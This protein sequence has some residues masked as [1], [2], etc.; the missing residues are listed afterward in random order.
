MIDAARGLLGPLAGPECLRSSRRGWVIWVRMA[1]ALAAA[2][3]VFVAFWF[4]WFLQLEDPY[5]LPYNEIRI[6]L[7]TVEGIVVAFAMILSPAVL[8]G[9]LAGEKERG[10]IGLLLTTR[11][12]ALEIVLGRL[13]G[14]LSQ[15]VM[16]EM[17]SLPALLLLAAFAGMGPGVTIALVA[18]PLAVT[19]GGAGIALGAS[20]LSRRGRDA[21]LF[22]YLVEALFLMSPLL[23]SVG[24]DWGGLLNPFTALGPLVSAEVAWP[25]FATA[26]LWASLGLACLVL[27]AWRLRVSCLAEG[28]EARGRSKARRRWPIPPVNE[29][30]ML[31]KELH[32]ERVGTL[33]RAGRWIGGALVAWLA[34]GSLAL[35]GVAAWSDFKDPEG[36][37]AAWATSQL[38]Y[39]YGDSSTAIL[40][41]IEL[42][43]GLR[44]AVGISSERERGT[45]DAL[46]TS[47][48]DGSEIVLGKLWGS[49]HA[50]RW[51]IG[52][53]L[54][55]W[56]IAAA[57]GGL[58]PGEYAELIISLATVGT[59]IAAIGVRTSLHAATATRSMG[60]TVGIAFGAYLL[61][62]AIAGIACF[63]VAIACVFGWMYAVSAGMATI[64]T[65]PWFPMTLRLGM[66]LVFFGLAVVS[67][68]LIVI[69]TRL[70]FDRVAG[71]MT[72]GAAAVAVEN[73]IHGRPMAPVLLGPKKAEE[74]VEV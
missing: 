37:W 53:A 71:R 65:P 59:L 29:R 50:L 45:W 21:L 62:K 46:L 57:L 16:I 47:P 17:A 34:L 42:A 70:R 40:V 4:A 3:V 28:S 20:S 69:E 63:A 24:L 66:D 14:R 22:V 74:V 6:A 26:G 31:W 58:L 54:L 10:S 32:I 35:A 64:R 67:T 33:G 1:S 18:L 72:G 55:A 52:S 27:G 73:L 56:T 61:G 15:V 44:A 19:F 2:S 25:A 51:L 9:S 60:V 38:S 5:H 41:L 68:V 7:V 49:L 48:L 30:P 13:A 36:T 11:V 39:W 43:I 12:N 23:G 8:A